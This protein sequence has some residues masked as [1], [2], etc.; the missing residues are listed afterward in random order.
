[1]HEVKR[2]IIVPHTP[3]R[4]FDL[5]D[6]V[7]AYPEFLPWCPAATVLHRDERTTRATLHIDFRG[8][9]QSF[10]TEN[11]KQPPFEM[12]LALVDGPFRSLAGGWR[13]MALGESGCRVEFRLA[14]EFSSGLLERLVGPVFGSIARDL[15]DAFV[16][17]ADRKYG[18]RGPGTGSR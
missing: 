10:T 3:S 8:I 13:F 14:Y 2:S 18:R 11:T 16:R 4:M 12:S 1:M 17:R 5:V 7:E 6:A 9:R 15:V